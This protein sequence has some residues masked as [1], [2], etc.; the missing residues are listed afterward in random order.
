[1]PRSEIPTVYRE[2]IQNLFSEIREAQSTSPHYAE[3]V[4]AMDELDKEMIDLM[5]ATETGWKL[6][7]PETFNQFS[8]KYR[9]A[10][11]LLEVY[12]ESTKKTQ[13]PAELGI[14]EKALKISELMAQDAQ[15]FR[16]YNP[17]RQKYYLS[18]PTLLEISRIPT[19]DLTHA[20]IKAIGGAQSSRWPMTV[21]GPGGEALPG[22]FTPALVYDPLKDFNQTAERASRA[23]N[24]TPA[25]ADLL[26]NFA[27]AYKAYYTAHPDNNHPVDPNPEMINGL[28]TACR[29]NPHKSQDLSISKDKVTQEI[30]KVNGMTVDEVKARIGSNGLDAITAGIRGQVF[31]V[32]IKTVELKMADKCRIDRKN[33][34][35]SIVAKLLNVSRVICHSESMKVKLSD[36]QVHDGTF[37][38]LADGVD[39][40]N[41]TAEATRAGSHSIKDGRGLEAI[42]DL[43]VLDYIC[44]NVDRHGG[45][46]F[47]QFDEEGNLIGVQGIDNDSCLGKDVPIEPKDRIRRLPVPATMGVISKKTADV[48]MNLEPEELAFALRG[49]IEE[50]EIEACVKRFKVMKASISFSRKQKEH[51]IKDIKYGK[52]REYTSEDFKNISKA[53]LK[54]LTSKDIHNHFYE[55]SERITY[56]AARASRANDK[57]KTKVMGD[58]NRAKLGGIIGQ[59]KLSDDMLQLL[60]DRSSIW[61]GSSSENYKDIERA[62]KKYKQL[63]ESM[64]D[65]I[66]DSQSKVIKGS[67]D[68]EDAYNQYVNYRDM[69]Q[70]KK[71][72]QNIKK[73]ADKYA[74]EKRQ[75]LALK[76][77]TLDDDKYIKARIEQAEEI[78]SFVANQFEPSEEEKKTL[79]ANDRQSLEDY[80]ANVV[81]A[82]QKKDQ[83]D[84]HSS[85]PQNEQPA[86]EIGTN[87]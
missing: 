20:Q 24:V 44:G 74:S 52:L 86:K 42:A 78:S 75:E 17:S 37:T 38:A 53:N 64:A 15:V 27:A 63:Q 5:N 29:T 48:I 39:P 54:R 26:K 45:N 41:P 82:K 28:I 67:T 66:K 70:M 51:E 77:K 7:D 10:A 12:L 73:A 16:Q 18:L 87:L 43:Q 13:D 32:G 62:I 61:R 76:G 55:A 19:V 11:T 4:K 83:A 34:G 33:T 8:L 22:V 59:I 23:K 60:K 84:L 49:T 21:F 1:M 31:D 58:T 50:K 35:M 80:T 6:L 81:K 30:A 9:A 25:G 47:Y 3:Y 69:K 85:D 46:L 36:G 65:R 56:L 57:L 79:D 71:A 72:L 14:R 40:A 68:P 2:E